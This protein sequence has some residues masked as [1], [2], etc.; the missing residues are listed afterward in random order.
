MFHLNVSNL[1]PYSSIKQNTKIPLE[2]NFRKSQIFQDKMKTNYCMCPV[3][4][5]RMISLEK[6]ENF[7]NS[8][9]CD[10]LKPQC[11]VI[12]TPVNQ[13]C[14]LYFQK[15]GCPTS[16]VPQY[17]YKQLSKT[18]LEQAQDEQDTAQRQQQDAICTSGQSYEDC[19]LQSNVPC[20]SACKTWWKKCKPGEDGDFNCKLTKEQEE[21]AQETADTQQQSAEQSICE[22]GPTRTRCNVSKDVP[23][24]SECKAWWKQ[25]RSYEDG[26]FNC[27]LTK[28]EEEAAQETQDQGSQNIIVDPS[29][30]VSFDCP[31]GKTS[32]DPEVCADAQS[33]CDIENNVP[34]TQQC[35]DFYNNCTNK[36]PASVNWETTDDT[37]KK[38]DDKP[39]KP[40]DTYICSDHKSVCD[41]EKNVPYTQ[42]CI[43]YYDNCTKKDPATI[44][45]NCTN[46]E[47]LKK[48][49]Q[50]TQYQTTD[51]CMHYF[52]DC[53]DPTSS[54]F[55]IPPNVIQKICDKEQANCL[56]KNPIF[57]FFAAVVVI[58][59]IGVVAHFI[60]SRF[61]NFKGNPVEEVSSMFRKS[62]DI[63]GSDDKTDEDV[64]FVSKDWGQDSNVE[65]DEEELGRK[66]GGGL[67][68]GGDVDVGGDADAGG[69]DAGG[70]D[71]GGGLLG[72]G[73]GDVELQQ[74]PRR[75]NQ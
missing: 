72:G 26:D 67:L 61:S 57:L 11:E 5:K 40:E 66:Q 14:S 32:C 24:D 39:E 55:P 63:Y 36:D 73:A 29:V 58:F 2:Y 48:R 37:P 51:E 12:P 59:F 10:Y 25:C 74:M 20:T 17:E 9:T 1:Y 33:I 65:Q 42:E 8:K 52:H 31:Q 30:P 19:N 4:T 56:Y 53:Y 44:D 41:I 46:I 7:I 27:P 54:G 34:D 15:D 13:N 23:C 64:Y 38:P 70:G 47:D 71:A 21:A 6:F 28:E 68:A 75:G 50:E 62:G 18:E 3:C 45:W 43:D 49:C 60:M 35:R 69:G 22:I 16:F